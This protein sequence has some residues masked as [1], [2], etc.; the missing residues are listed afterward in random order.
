MFYLKN[1]VIICLTN[2]TVCNYFYNS[3]KLYVEVI[4]FYVPTVVT[5]L[6]YGFVVK[7]NVCM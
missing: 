2:I 7:L 1:N 3:L 4:I 5:L 6:L